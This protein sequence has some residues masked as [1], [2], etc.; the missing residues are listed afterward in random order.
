MNY[1]PRSLISRNAITAAALSAIVMSG[2]GFPF[3]SCDGVS[4]RKV[5]KDPRE[6]ANPVCSD[7]LRAFQLASDSLASKPAKSPQKDSSLV[8]PTPVPCPLTK[9]ELGEKTWSLLHTMAAYYPESPS[10]EQQEAM[11][12]FL[13]ALSLLYPCP[14]CA[15]DFAESIKASPPRWLTQLLRL[16]PKLLIPKHSAGLSLKKL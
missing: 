8:V 13:R 3:S 5:A 2:T 4:Q 9:G 1:L 14:Y 7:S 10:K 11:D 6:C 16:I 15:E 12:S